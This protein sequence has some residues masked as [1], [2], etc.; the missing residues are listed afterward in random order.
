MVFG[1][2]VQGFEIVRLIENLATDDKSRPLT[3]VLVS[4]CGE[5]VLKAKKK[6][7]AESASSSDSKKKRKK[8]KK[9]SK[10]TTK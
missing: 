10:K 6:K 8:E 4:H 3:K 9:K 1:E 7:R 5:L 2:V